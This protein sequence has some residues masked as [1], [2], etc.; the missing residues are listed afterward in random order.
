MANC[1]QE[2]LA[3]ETM[4]DMM[5]F[6]IVYGNKTKLPAEYQCPRCGN[7]YG[8]HYFKKHI[9]VCD[10]TCR[11]V[12]G[13]VTCPGCGKDFDEQEGQQ[14]VFWLSIHVKICPNLPPLAEPKPDHK[15]RRQTCCQ[16]E[17]QPSM[18]S[19]ITNLEGQAG[20]VVDE[21]HDELPGC[22]RAIPWD[23]NEF[24]AFKLTED[25][26]QRPTDGVQG[27]DCQEIPQLDRSSEGQPDFCLLSLV[28]S[29]LKS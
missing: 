25:L 1:D 8:R 18:T 23:R 26:E 20:L 11:M 14:G 21:N 10:H 15:Y 2:S 24:R 29:R 12:A 9:Q 3:E 13:Q 4:E 19:E 5:S 16:R 22:A 27:A 28:K 6:K 7:N 17:G